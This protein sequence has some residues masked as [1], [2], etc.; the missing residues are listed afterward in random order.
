M[1]KPVIPQKF[2]VAVEVQKDKKYAWCSC[3]LSQNQ[4]FC[5][6][7]HKS[8]TTEL[9]PK[10]VTFDETK[11]VYWCCCKHTQSELGLCDGTHKTL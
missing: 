7:A 2:P 3:G 4:P 11:T 10:I 9:R 8:N 1:D 5:D 6:G